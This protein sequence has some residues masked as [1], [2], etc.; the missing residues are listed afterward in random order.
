IPMYYPLVPSLTDDAQPR[1]PILDTNSAQDP[2]AW[3]TQGQIADRTQEHLGRSDRGIILFRQMLED[4]IA[5]VEQGLDPMNTFR[6][7]SSNVYL[8]MR[9]ERPVGQR[10]AGTL[11][12]QGDAP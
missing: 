9:T 12:R 11:V 7:A 1:W 5:R 2:A 6:E 8:S 10:Y 4:N 3:I